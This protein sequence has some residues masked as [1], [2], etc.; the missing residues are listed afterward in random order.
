MG[1][2]NCNHVL[3][4]LL[5]LFSSFNIALEPET[6]FQARQS[7]NFHNFLHDLLILYKPFSVIRG[8]K[9]REMYNAL[10]VRLRA[11]IVLQRYIKSK[12]AR[13]EFLNIQKA[14]IVIQTGTIIMNSSHSELTTNIPDN[15]AY[16]SFLRYPR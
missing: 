3:F 14:A 1:L 5:I 9:T 4:C 16:Y 8:Q 10:V 12:I 13:R 6:F 11:S 7:F 15:Y 2:W